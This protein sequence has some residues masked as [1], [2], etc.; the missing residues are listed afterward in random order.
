[1]H[2]YNGMYIYNACPLTNG[3][4]YPSRGEA[5]NRFDEGHEVLPHRSGLRFRKRAV[6]PVDEYLYG[7]W[8][9]IQLVQYRRVLC[10]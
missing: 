10:I 2:I 4:L 9:E 6:Q 8:V 5:L 3:P 7:V 1:M